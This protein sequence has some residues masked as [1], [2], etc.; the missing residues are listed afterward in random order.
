MDYYKPRIDDM[1]FLL[2]TFGYDEVQALPG[3][4]DYDIDT[5]SA[6]LEEG[7]KVLVNEF[8]PLNSVGDR[9]GLEF[10]PE[11]GAVTT[12]P[13]FKKA[14]RLESGRGNSRHASRRL[15]RSI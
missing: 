1:R 12:P 2:E 14:R 3:N 15:G 11:T 7:A 10:N 13:G 6:V 5:V 9:V 4:S 8:L